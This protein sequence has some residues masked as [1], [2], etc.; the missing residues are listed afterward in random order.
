[1]FNELFLNETSVACTTTKDISGIYRK[2]SGKANMK[3]TRQKRK[4][5]GNCCKHCHLQSPSIKLKSIITEDASDIAEKHHT[6]ESRQFLQP[7][8]KFK[9]QLFP[10]DEDTRRVLQEGDHNPYLELTLRPRKKISSV[11]THLTIKWGIP[12]AAYELPLGQKTWTL[13]DRETSAADVY[14]TVGQPEI[15]RLKYGLYPNP[16]SENSQPP[17]GTYISEKNLQSRTGRSRNTVEGEEQ[18][19]P[20]I[21]QELEPVPANEAGPSHEPDKPVRNTAMGGSSLL[22]W[23]DCVTSVSVGQLLSET[24]NA[25]QASQLPTEKNPSS[26]HISNCDSFDFAIAD[27]I[28][29]NQYPHYSTQPPSLSSIWDAEETRHAFPTMKPTLSRTKTS[30]A[31]DHTAVQVRFS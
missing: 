20:L 27:F 10:I 17:P 18:P 31:C 22:S 6:V 25:N 14:S 16:G 23:V 2:I 28:A 11:V 24:S 26:K 15:F 29:R 1:M 3:A 30:P 19:H 7:S 21:T 4:T 5:T 9:L 13:N 12:R 8:D